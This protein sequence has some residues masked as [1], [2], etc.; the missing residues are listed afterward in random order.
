MRIKKYTG[1]TSE[2]DVDKLRI[3]LTKSGALVHEV[4]E[5]LDKIQDKL[6]DQITTKELYKLAFRELKHVS[7]S[8]AARYSLKKALRDL[9]PTGFYFEK[10]VAKFLASYGYNTTT[11]KII[12]G[13]AV[14][15]EADVIAQKGDDLLWIEC[16]FRNMND[17]KVS[18]TT[19][20][21]ILSRV[22]DIS[23]KKH[24]LFGQQLQFTQGWL[25]TNA[26]LTV[27]AIAFGEYYQLKLLSW[28]YPV[29]KSIKNLVDQKAL[30]PVT[31]LTT[32]NL[33][34]KQFLLENDCI[35]V[36]EFMENQ[37][38]LNS[39]FK[40]PKKRELVLQEMTE[41]INYQVNDEKIY[42]SIFEIGSSSTVI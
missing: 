19:P 29:H 14:N 16:K 18:V 15:H 20:M 10:W 30:Y 6:Y 3:S 35:L 11:N 39:M 23:D 9:G 13:K 34:E 37:T 41:L 31:C 40:D 25:V 12:R 33:K 42:Q 24:D 1:E 22:K 8:L 17:G 2:F 38:L 4:D 36:K 26:I 32:I 28:E 5:V 27:D 7:N 21:Y